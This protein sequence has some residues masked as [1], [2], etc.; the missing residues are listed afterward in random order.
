MAVVAD[1]ET[2]VKPTGEEEVAAVALSL[3]MVGAVVVVKAE[4]VV[5]AFGRGRG[6]PIEVEVFS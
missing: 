3:K 1:A 2:R 5:G 6:G 4:A